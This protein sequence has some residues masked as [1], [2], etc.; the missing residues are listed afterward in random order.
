MKLKCPKGVTSINV[1]GVEY[2]AD[3]GAV[4]I[5]DQQH[6]EAAMKN[7]FTIDQAAMSTSQTITE[8]DSKPT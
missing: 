5:T 4:T 2:A 6:I 3:K 1:G 8:S 7:G